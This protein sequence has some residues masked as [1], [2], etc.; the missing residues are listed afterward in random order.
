M[1]DALPEEAEKRDALEIVFRQT[2]QCFGFRAIQTPVVEETRLFA[3]SLG[4]T[5]DVVMKEMYAVS[6]GASAGAAAGLSGSG[7]SALAPGPTEHLALRPEGTAGAMRALLNSGT[8]RLP[9]ASQPI[10]DGSPTL[11]LPIQPTQRLFYC[12][13]M[14]RHERPQKGRFRQFSQLGVEMVGGL[15]D[16]AAD[17]EVLSMAH[18]FLQRALAGSGIRVTLLLNSLGDAHSMK[19]YSAA[20]H[21]HFTIAH[22]AGQRAGG[23]APVLSPLSLARL[24]R[25]APLRILDSKDAGDQ[26]IAASAPEI[27]ACWTPSAAARFAAVQEGL[28]ALG[29]P[30][31][32][33]PRL[34]RGLDYYRHTIF[35]FVASASASASPSDP[36]PTP[37]PSSVLPATTPA[38]VDGGGSKH[39]GSMWGPI[40]V[41][42]SDSPAASS[43]AAAET[44]PLGTLLAGGRYDGL[45]AIIGSGSGSSA[46]FGDVPAVGE[47]LCLLLPLLN[48]EVHIALFRGQHFAHGTVFRID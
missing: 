31:E 14:F 4:D 10:A 30:F 38:R 2:A 11:S 1:H 18:T 9:K 41:D 48:P 22:A 15:G 35:E 47:L 43:T 20:L 34:V 28:A 3:R 46:A 33:A 40:G 6:A 7:S 12:G 23:G 8:I 39:A 25:G 44:S 17:V 26:A 29:I 37:L 45:A 13:P 32:R 24:E 21:E 5:S 19:A 42:G 16:A 27:D 36:A